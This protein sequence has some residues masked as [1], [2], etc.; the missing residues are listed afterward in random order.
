MNHKNNSRILQMK[1]QQR[2][3]MLDEISRQISTGKRNLSELQAQ[4]QNIL[5]M[6][7]QIMSDYHNHSEEHNLAEEQL[8]KLLEEERQMAKDLKSI[9]RHLIEVQSIKSS[10]QTAFDAHEEDIKIHKRRV[11]EH[12]RS[13]DELNDIHTSLVKQ[14]LEHKNNIERN[15]NFR[16]NLFNHR[17]L[18]AVDKGRSLSTNY[19]SILK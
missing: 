4:N 5:T 15:N 19:S 9:R 18:L 3:E 10:L 12:K 17:E 14:N 6:E 1:Q 11:D 13:H 2:E 7:S 8:K 16:K